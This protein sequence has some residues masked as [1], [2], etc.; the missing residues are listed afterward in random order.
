LRHVGVRWLAGLLATLTGCLVD[1]DEP[2]GDELQPA[3]GGACV[4]PEGTRLL[5]G[6]CV[7][8]EASASTNSTSCAAGERCECTS[9]S[10]CPTGELCDTFGSGRCMAAPAGLGNACTNSADCAGGEATYCDSYSTRTC[11]VQGC[12]ELG[13]VCP[14]DFLCCEYAIISTSLCVPPATAPGGQCPAP[15]SLVLRSASP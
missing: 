2:C 7:A 8:S 5:E 13:G 10:D 4:C 11:V 3:A 15:G 9:S 1:A 12:K 14:G 6:K